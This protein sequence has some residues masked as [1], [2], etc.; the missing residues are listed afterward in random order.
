MECNRW[1]HFKGRGKKSIYNGKHEILST[2][3]NAH[4]LVGYKDTLLLR[5]HRSELVPEQN[6]EPLVLTPTTQHV[7][8]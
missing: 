4:Y 7:V 6:L 1:S 3:F 2:C 8:G 5:P